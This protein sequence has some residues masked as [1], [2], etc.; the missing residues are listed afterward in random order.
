L[1]GIAAEDAVAAIIAAEVGQGDK[2]FARISD[3]AWLEALLGRQSGGEE[4]GKF[5]VWGMN[6]P[7]GALAGKWQP[8]AQFVE[9]SRRRSVLWSDVFSYRQA[10]Q[11]RQPA[12]IEP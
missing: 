2:D 11:P 7:A 4:S 6:K 1:A 9:K 8:M 12:R 3:N 10:S 5:V